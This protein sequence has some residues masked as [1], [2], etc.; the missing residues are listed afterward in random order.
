MSEGTPPQAPCWK[1]GYPN[2][3]AAEKVK[4]NMR[5][6]KRKRLLDAYACKEC[7]MAHLGGGIR[8]RRD[9]RQMKRYG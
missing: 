6:P 4:R 1:V 2:V 7:G 9:S 8:R 3:A 5:D